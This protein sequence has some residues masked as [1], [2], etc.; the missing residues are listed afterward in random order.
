MLA[1][2]D[3]GDWPEL[4][5]RA[6]WRSRNEDGQRLSLSL[7]ELEGGVMAKLMAEFNLVRDRE[8]AANIASI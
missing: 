2:W 4:C 8:I 6:L 3:Q 5:Y 1:R 7:A